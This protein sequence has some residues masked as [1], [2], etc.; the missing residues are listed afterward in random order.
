MPESWNTGEPSQEVQ[1]QQG[2]QSPGRGH[3]G[4][5]RPTQPSAPQ[6]DPAPFWPADPAAPELVTQF[7]F[8]QAGLRPVFPVH[9][10]LGSVLKSP[11]GRVV[12]GAGSAPGS[13]PPGPVVH[14]LRPD[15]TPWT[16]STRPFP[17]AAT[18]SGPARSAAL[19]G[20]ELP[21]CLCP[22]TPYARPHP[23]SQAPGP[24]REEGRGTGRGGFRFRSH[25]HLGPRGW[26]RRRRRLPLPAPPPA[27]R[28]WLPGR[29]CAGAGT[30]FPVTEGSDHRE[31]RR[32][33]RA[34]TPHFRQPPGPREP[35]GRP[36][37]GRRG[38]LR[39]LSGG[40]SQ[41]PQKPPRQG[42]PP[43]ALPEKTW[44]REARGGHR[45]PTPPVVG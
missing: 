35:S 1:T 37:A 6:A 7:L 12:E 17:G 38:G 30:P 44:R 16:P 25:L 22:P 36:E 31:A 8:G 13:D 39:G 5:H 34:P 4:S 2:A 3:R 27:L 40:A 18:A 15:P 29:L 14:A 24:G 9:L 41:G 26:L 21:S 32:E 10:P 43:G 45:G 23:D 11:E 42:H 28:D 19:C 33:G 20:A